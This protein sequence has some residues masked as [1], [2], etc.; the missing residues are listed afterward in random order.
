MDLKKF[1]TPLER[2][3]VK[4]IDQ[5]IAFVQKYGKNYSEPETTVWQICE[6]SK[7]DIQKITKVFNFNNL[8]Y[9]DRRRIDTKIVDEEIRFDVSIFYKLYILENRSGFLNLMCGIK[10]IKNSQSLIFDAPLESVVYNLLDLSF[11]MVLQIVR[12]VEE[13]VEKEKR[14]RDV[15]TK[16]INEMSRKLQLL[17]EKQKRISSKSIYKDIS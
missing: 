14:N 13:D 1:E 4:L 7:S 8:D 11:E 15:I 10:E 12:W 3:K 9:N 2:T 6:K 5:L 17:L 16:E